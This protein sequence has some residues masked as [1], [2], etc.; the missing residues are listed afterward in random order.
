MHKAEMMVAIAKQW[1]Q[2]ERTVL[3]VFERPCYVLDG[4]FL[5]Q[6][7][8]FTRSQFLDNP[9]FFAILTSRNIHKNAK[10]ISLWT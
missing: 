8:P 4:A 3:N 2:K 9:L 5:L 6:R 1:E 10:E 7:P